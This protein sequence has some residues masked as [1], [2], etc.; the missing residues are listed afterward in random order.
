M[1]EFLSPP[2]Y[3]DPRAYVRFLNGCQCLLFDPGSVSY[4]SQVFEP[5]HALA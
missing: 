1:K 5:D 3:F 4:D 2:H